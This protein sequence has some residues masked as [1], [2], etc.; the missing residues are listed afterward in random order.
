[1]GPVITLASKDLRLLFRDRMDLFFTFVFPLFVAIFFGAIFGGGGSGGGHGGSKM[2]IALVDEDHS[3][4][5]AAFVSRIENSDEFEVHRTAL[6]R[7]DGGT[8]TREQ[9]NDLVRKGD[10][11]ACVVLPKGF[12]A[13]ADNLF[14]GEPIRIE[15]TIDPSR[16]AESGMLQGILTKYA[17]QGMA[18]MFGDADRMKQMARKNLEDVRNAKGMDPTV[19]AALEQFLPSVEK[20]FTDSD[21]P[22]AK[23]ESKA[24]SAIAGWEPVKV[25]LTEMKVVEDESDKAGP[26]S[27]YMVS[28]PQAIIWGILGCVTSFAIS[29]TTERAGGTLVRLMLSPIG[30]WQILAGK[31][32]ACFATCL[33][34]SCAVLLLGRAAFGVAPRSVPML[35][36]AIVCIGLG[37]VGVMMLVATIG[38]TAGGSSGLG[39]GLLLMLAM[40]G[41]GSIPMFFMP[42]WMQTVSSISPFKWAILA[43]DGAIWRPLTWAEFLGPCAVLLGFGVAGFALGARLFE[44]TERG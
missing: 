3:A 6:P 25:E 9:G 35:A 11:V 17:F 34:V 33:I 30:R 13:S 22:A 24:A 28:F 4:A 12:G 20:F 32:L 37:F 2:R 26:K 31:A 29:L 8:L 21:K 1:M 14:R 16:R 44:W 27:S 10:M 41:G 5:S 39:R 23:G 18:E 15:G 40:I 38:K 43:L 42:P 36:V 7:W 19:K